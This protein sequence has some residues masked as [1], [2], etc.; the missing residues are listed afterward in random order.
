M[1]C[2]IDYRKFQVVS[3]VCIHG[4]YN[5]TFTIFLLSSLNFFHYEKKTRLLMKM[6]KAMQPAELF[7]NIS[8]ARELIINNKVIPWV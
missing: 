1:I 8:G 6:S 2:Y 3:R 5:M 7:I 4:K